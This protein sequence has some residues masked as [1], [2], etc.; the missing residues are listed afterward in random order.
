MGM[1]TGGGQA[2]T[3]LGG[4]AGYGEV[5]LD[6]G[7][8]TALRL[9]ASAVFEAGLNYFGQPIAATDIWVNTNGTVSLG[10]VFT[11]YPTATNAQPG[12][13]LIAPLWGDVDTRLRGEG[14]ESGQIHVDLDAASDCLT[15]TWDMVGVYRRDTS[16]PNRVQMQLFDR[17]GGDFDIVFRYEQVGW[18]TGTAPDDAGARALLAAPGLSAVQVMPGTDLAL[19]DQL[20]GN[21]GITGMWVWRMRGGVLQPGLGS[22]GTEGH[23]LLQGTTGADHIDALGGNDTVLA[24]AGADTVLGGLGEDQLHGGAGADSLLGG[25]GH[26]QLWGD[27]GNDVLRGEAGNDTA[28]G[29][30]GADTL[31]GGD[32]DDA[33]YGGP[34]DGDLRDVIYGGAGNDQLFGGGGNDSQSGGLGS[35]TVD[36]GPGADTLIGNEG[37]DVLSGGPGADVIFG[38]DG[39]DW[40]NGGF[41]N[42][43]LNG[44]AGADRFY[45]L[46]IP[47]HGS[48][49]IQDYSGVEGDRLLFGQPGAQ[50]SQF[51]VNY[52]HTSDASGTPAGQVEVAEAFVIYK[53]TGQIIW[54]L[55]DGAGQ[56]AIWLQL[57][58]QLY[59]LVP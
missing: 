43:R 15:V 10:A 12:A 57:G 46:G 25:A 41:G 20:A 50:A 34:D 32:G 14:V 40:I 53:P 5:T 2:V 58:G 55:V 49:W 7:D 23:D 8:D 3:G 16:A 56:D 18:T 28:Y 48:D 31:D 4:S 6:R 13:S 39:D 44:G 38:N 21:T 33:L 9:D 19:L 17:G 52:A 22:A 36:G 51:Q 54:A 42:D 59:D 26:D 27:D 11:A 37:N 1:I 35:D 47:D 30:L 24:D 45:H 29:G